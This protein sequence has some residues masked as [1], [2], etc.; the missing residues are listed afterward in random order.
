MKFLKD[1]WQALLL[2]FIA[3]IAVPSILIGF[4][5]NKSPFD[6]IYGSNDAWIGFWGS[7]AGGLMTAAASGGLAYYISRRESKLAEE[8]RK[9]MRINSVKS[10]LLIREFETLKFEILEIVNIFSKQE[11]KLSKF[12]NAS[13]QFYEADFDERFDLYINFIG[14]EIITPMDKK[15]LESK[16]NNLR[17]VRMPALMV[18]RD[19][20]SYKELIQPLENAYKDLVLIPNEIKKGY[21]NPWPGDALC[22]EERGKY[23][24]SIEFSMPNQIEISRSAIEHFNSYRNNFNK[25]LFSQ[26][27]RL[28]D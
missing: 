23:L 4:F 22:D 2:V 20:I 13:T 27:E 10:E 5:Y 1:Y 21:I 11:Q 12:L 15:E 17:D 14:S 6:N 25:I 3:V 28:I 24:S 7:Y 18:K 9:Q 8:K 16:I 19:G 26:L